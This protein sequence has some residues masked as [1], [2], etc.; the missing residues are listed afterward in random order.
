MEMNDL[1][2][3]SV[4][5]HIV[6]PPTLFDNHLTAQQRQFAPRQVR[7]DGV[8][9]WLF[10]DRVVANMG[11]AAVAGRKRD[12]YGCDPARF[13]QM[14]RGAWDIKARVDDMNVNGLCSS[15]NFPTIVGFDGS[16]FWGAQD[17]NN[18]LMA[19]KAY[20]DWHMEEMV[21]AHPGR[22]IA[23]GVIPA[24]D[25][26]ETASEMARLKSKG[27]N[28]ITFSDNP[29][30]KGLPS[31]HSDYWKPMWKAA[32]ENEMVINLHIGTGYQPPHPSMES[33]IDAWTIIMPMSIAVAA[34]DWLHLKAVREYGLKIA[35]SE[36]GIGWIPY[37]LERANFTHAHHHEWTNSDFGK[38]LPS[39]VFKEHF[40]T[41]FIEDRFGLQSLENM[42]EDMVC[43]ECDYP[44][45]DT[46]WPEG[47][48]FLWSAIKSLPQEKIDK[49]THLNAM[50]EYKFD[51]FS[52]LGGKQN[53][54]V[55][56]LRALA[57]HV[58]TTPQSFGGPAPINRG[59][60]R[61]VTSRDVI[62][63]YERAGMKKH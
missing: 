16:L 54:T 37:F 34:A 50:R 57:K 29:S 47:P 38:Q 15:L 6:E 39:E 35:L 18:S 14:R 21:D 52:A 8:D 33:P 30:Q 59:E 53:C 26:R 48:E 61:V 46:V 58:D 5:D 13:D 25:M 43:Y 12:E 23:C 49:I 31:I 56:A 27:C 41:C 62:A 1:I 7:K 17:K 2:M 11:L 24:W 36:G 40:I 63:M 44:H 51:P 3:V 10:E 60:R 55:G 32:A 28:S 22:F 42:N 9:L 45:S 19:L 4:D 20:N